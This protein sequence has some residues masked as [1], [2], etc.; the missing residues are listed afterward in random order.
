M[1]SWILLKRW[2][3][4]MIRLMLR[5]LKKF[6]GLKRKTLNSNNSKEHNSQDL[7]LCFKVLTPK[8]LRSS[9]FNFKA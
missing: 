7:F 4:D 3:A 5:K 8:N 6:T 9:R 2:N 1:N